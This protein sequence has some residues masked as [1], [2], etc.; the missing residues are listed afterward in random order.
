MLVFRGSI[1]A[2]K[3]AGRENVCT[4]QF[5]ERKEDGVLEFI[6]IRMPVG[7]NHD[8]YKQGT[9]VEIPVSVTALMGRIVYK[10]TGVPLGHG[11]S[12]A[13]K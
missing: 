9:E 13:A 7:F 8:A 10:A 2:K 1:E 6:E 12:S 5:I 11:K 4:F 3:I